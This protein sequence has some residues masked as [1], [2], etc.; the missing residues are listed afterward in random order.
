MNKKVS[1]RDFARASVAAGAAAAAVSLPTALLGT[2]PAE[3][4]LSAKS[5]A[6]AKG[7]AVAR[8]RRVALPPEVGYGGMDSTGRDMML[9]ETAFTNQTAVHP[10]GWRKGTTIPA[11]YYV[12]EKHYLNDERVIAESFWFMAD[13][14]S[15][16]PKAGTISSLSSDAETVSS[17]SAT[18]PAP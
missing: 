2:A 17:S 13:H 12:D 7:A 15:R 3:K 18:R 6:A 10:G 14:E 5:S 1:R 11:E 16:I 4:A 8:R 9:D